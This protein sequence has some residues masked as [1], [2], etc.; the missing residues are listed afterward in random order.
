MHDGD[1]DKPAAPEGDAA[2]AAS[3]AEKAESDQA[4]AEKG[5]PDKATAD[6]ATADKATADKAT[7][8]KADKAAGGPP[9]GSQSSGP[10]SGSRRPSGKSP[11][12]SAHKSDRPPPPPDP[13][14]KQDVHEPEKAAWGEPF[15]KLDRA[16][17]L[18]ESRL[19]AGVL[20]AEVVTLVFWIA[21]RALSSTGR[22]GPG[23][24]FRALLT[25][26]V[27]GLVAHKA[28]K[29][30]ERHEAITT[31]AAILGLV[32]GSQWGDAGT[33]YFSNVFAWLQNASILVFFGGVS[34]MAKRFTLWLALLGAS[35]ATAQGKHINVDVVMRFL[36]PRAR[37]PV[38]VLGWVAAAIVSLSASWGFFDYVCVEELRAP[39][40][41]ACPNEPSGSTKRCPAPP[42][43]KIDKVL[44]SASR[45]FFLARRQVSL[46][47]RSLPKVITGT[48]YNKWM[49][50]Q[51]WNEWLRG[52]GWESH[53]KPEDVKAFELPEDGSVD[54]RNPSV[55]AIPG[56]TEA[57][58]K[59]LV[60]LLNLVFAF[61]L[62]VIGLRFILRSLLA[63]SGWVKVDPAAAHGDDELA[64]AHDHSPAAELA[65]AAIKETHS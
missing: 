26:L 6:K 11:W 25:S 8:D 47:F 28:S 55:T 3:A 62:F 2:P 50:P 59:I 1:K 4:T 14:A 20:I 15:A 54:F 19:C 61:G 65:E 52:G 48:P 12:P 34:E 9:S 29:K 13:P 40:T 39:P 10:P 30:H 27:I 41:I 22:A 42:G 46:D 43:S 51:E 56:G 53:F 21:I 64:H 32:V 57:I 36:S 7:A 45:N 33:A 17:T 38:A 5:T 35:L 18:L 24:I 23:M 63:I 49:T 37:I 16:W 58:P 60:P 44:S 31:G